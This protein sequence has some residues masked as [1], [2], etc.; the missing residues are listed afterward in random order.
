MTT[1]SDARP[2]GHGTGVKS[3][4]TWQRGSS[5]PIIPPPRAPS[6]GPYAATAMA[7]HDSGLG[8]PLPIPAG[9]KTPPPPGWTGAAGLVASRADVGAWIDQEG[10]ANVAIRLADGVIGIDVDAY[11]GKGG[12]STLAAA[13]AAYGPL[14]GTVTTTSRD[15]GVS[16]IRLYRVPAGTVLVGS[17]AAAGHGPAVEVIQPHHRY[18]M[19]APSVHPEGPR[20]RWVGPDF[21]DLSPG[22]V[23][24]VGDL[25]E[26]PASWVEGL[27]A[28][29]VAVGAEVVAPPEGWPVAAVTH[30]YV[31]ALVVGLATDTPRG[32]WH[33]WAHAAC[34]RLAAASSLGLLTAGVL[35]AAQRALVGRLEGARSSRS[36]GEPPAVE[37]ARCW[38]DAVAR[39]ARQAE[40][41]RQSS[42]HGTVEPVAPLRPVE[43]GG[44]VIGTAAL[45][46]PPGSAA[47]EPDPAAE[48]GRAPSWAPADLSAYLDGTHVPQVPTLLHR[49]DGAALLYAGR[50]HSFHGESESGKSW[51]ALVAAVQSL[52]AGQRVLV[53]DFE[54][55]AA[56]VVGRLLLLGADPAVVR[57]RLDYVRPDVSPAALADEGEAFKALL[58]RTYAVAVLDGV[59]EALSVFGRESNSNDDLTGWV[60]A[61]PRRIAERTG[62]ALILVDHVVKD[63]ESRGRFAI[64]GQAKM[65]ALDGAAYVVEVLQPLGVGLRGSVALRVAK[66]RPGGV[67]PHA[68][69]WRRS[70]R[71]QEA[72]VVVL[73]STTPGAVAVSIAPPRTE[74]ATG[75]TREGAGETFRPTVLMARV[76]DAVQRHGP[77]TRTGLEQ[78]V[79]GRA[80]YVRQALEVLLADG[81]ITA[82]GPAVNGGRPMLCHAR[83]FHPDPVPGDGTG[84][85]HGPSDPV[86]TLSHPV[87]GPRDG[88]TTGEPDPVPPS[89]PYRGDGVVVA[90]TLWTPSGTG[91]G[92]SASCA[93]C[94]KAAAWQGIAGVSTCTGC[95]DAA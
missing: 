71:T 61:V 81:F 60:R 5:T 7:V 91:S 10:T 73:D 28:T 83:P 23:P 14:P 43:G 30:P 12:A 16:G 39:T 86:P 78:L 57:D 50:V 35:A 79:S 87:P 37:V 36:S 17:L 24:S 76:S 6:P 42:L 51:V 15:D 32:D 46:P 74:A 41:Q 4:D 20:Y 56:T 75:A 85:V 1:T 89:H 26:L 64:G 11:A 38:A 90:G 65:A 88:V 2:A 48:V 94:G 49:D 47:P 27:A 84:S 18:A 69:A 72:A 70:D 22:V 19:A 29:R 21:T 62:A 59:T 55:D 68:G 45:A 3:G 34:C 8:S 77:V 93:R 31:E 80:T 33:A 54:S 63:S 44:L 58:T 53:L 95:R 66:D 82:D 13:V 92:G 25:P 40:D 67:R 9:Q 52:A